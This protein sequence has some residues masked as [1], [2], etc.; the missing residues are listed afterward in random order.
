MIHSTRNII[1]LLLSLL[2][3][4]ACSDETLIHGPKEVEEGVPVTATF[5]FSASDPAKIE[6]K[7]TDIDESNKVS[8]LAV[9]IFKMKKDGTFEK[10]GDTKICTAEEIKNNSI[11]I[12]TTSGTRYVYAIANYKS[13]LYTINESTLS[14]IKFVDELKKLSVTLPINTD[15][16]SSI[17]VLDGMFLMSG[18]VVATNNNT[19]NFN[20]ACTIDTKG[21]VNGRILLQRIMSSI[22][23][24][25][26]CIND[27]AKFAVDSW[28]VKKLPQSSYVFERS[29]ASYEDYPGYYKAS[30]IVPPYEIKDTIYNGLNTES[31]NFSFLMM[32]NRKVPNENPTTYDDREK[33]EAPAVGREPEQFKVANEQSTYVVIKGTYNG[34][35]NQEVAG[36]VANNVT[37]FTTYYVHLGNWNNNKWDD[38]NIFRNNRYIYTVKVLSVDKLIVE[39][40]E[41]NE[42]G[43]NENWGGDG[44]M[45]LSS[46]EKLFDAHYET[47][48]ISFTKK[49]IEELF[50]TGSEEDFINSFPIFASTPKNNFNSDE[51]DV[52]WVTYKRNTNSNPSTEFMPYQG[53]AATDQ[54]LL[55]ALDL[56]KD[57]YKVYGE[58]QSDNDRVY[59]TCFIDEYFYGDKEGNSSSMRTSDFVNQQPRTIQIGS[60]YKKNDNHSSTSSVSKAAY[61]FTQRSISSVYDLDR[62]DNNNIN[63]WGTEWE[64]KEVL[65]SKEP[66]G[67][68][69]FNQGIVNTW[70]FLTGVKYPTDTSD[71]GVGDP[72]KYIWLNLYNSDNVNYRWETY[73]DD[74][75]NT[76]K[77]EYANLEYACLSRNRDLN[78]NGVIDKNELRWYLPAINQYMGLVIGENVL[79]QEARLYNIGEPN[80][81]AKY[82][83][84]SSSIYYYDSQECFFALRASEGLSFGYQGHSAGYP[85]KLNYRCIRNL[86]RASEFVTDLVNHNNGGTTDGRAFTSYSFENLNPKSRRDKVNGELTKGH[87]IFDEENRLPY[88]FSAG[89]EEKNTGFTA[90]GINLINPCKNAK[91]GWR[92]PNQRELAIM[93]FNNPGGGMIIMRSYFSCTKFG[94]RYCGYNGDQTKPSMDIWDGNYGDNIVFQYEEIV[95]REVDQYRCVKDK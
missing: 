62:V 54:D 93:T 49:M 59:Y 42:D 72:Y 68:N 39:V 21:R 73:L 74:K 20:T 82:A 15:Q 55:S 19:I 12:A 22:Q 85:N 13:S 90:S 66:L 94:D 31:Y 25:V 6:T 29:S 4:T 79:P 53:D 95:E 48:I 92:L 38:F 26:M 32:E 37:A 67:K 91:D 45:Y 27:D 51:T 78:G 69:N 36:T 44:E 61:I 88:A 33:M 35:T 56:K 84:A 34:P 86:R 40:I 8:S 60:Y 75:Y 3:C 46:E 11:S 87:T 14:E 71:P 64:S 43:Q 30:K 50:E 23:F 57:L 70:Y 17:S 83:Y 7:A 81:P 28:Q 58:M 41:K 16:S 5:S 18:C 47:T 76:L 89:A 77:D 10:I 52:N 24:R 63:G 9:F 65:S 2:A 1:Y 80:D